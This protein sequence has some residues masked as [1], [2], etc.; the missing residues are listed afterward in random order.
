MHRILCNYYR[1]WTKSI[2]RKERYIICKVME[3][4]PNVQVYICYNF[5][6]QSENLHGC[7]IDRWERVMD[8]FWYVIVIIIITVR[9][10]THKSQ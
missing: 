4:Q 5:F 2:T 7:Q 3:K 6:K 1:E 9:H 8:G 10:H